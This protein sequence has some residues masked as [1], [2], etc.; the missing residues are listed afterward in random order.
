MD[1]HVAEVMQRGL[2]DFGALS[3][4]EQA[5]FHVRMS[6]VVNQADSA[7]TMVDKGLLAE[8]LLDTNVRICVS[9]LK[10]AGG[11]Q[12]W[13]DVGHQYRNHQYLE[14][15]LTAVDVEPFDEMSPWKVG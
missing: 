10:T 3:Q 9:L 1:E 12:W 13:S 8:D 6:G 5:V 2:N 14:D 4:P 15:R 11:G 7:K